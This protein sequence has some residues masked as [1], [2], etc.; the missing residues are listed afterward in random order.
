LS[1][2]WNELHHQGDVGLA[3]Y[4]SVPHIIRISKEKRLLN[5][6]IFG[7]ISTIEIERHDGNPKLPA[8]F[9]D[10]YFDSLKN[11]IPEL[12]EMCLNDNWDLTLTSTILSV[13]AIS[14]GHIEMAK[15]ISK[16]DDQDV[17]S[18]FLENF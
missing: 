8:E 18:E 13:L 1:E 15:A 9:E 3:S 4:L 5:Y 12:V 17:T 6:N 11:G 10:S 14:K 2:L 7:L 16:M